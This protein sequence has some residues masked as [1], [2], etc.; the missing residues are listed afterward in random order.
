MNFGCT[1][2]ERA[3]DEFI[4]TDYQYL[5][6]IFLCWSCIFFAFLTVF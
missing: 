1:L 5:T 2:C 3:M 4:L 6:V